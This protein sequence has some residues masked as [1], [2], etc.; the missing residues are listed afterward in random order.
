MQ[1]FVT[2]ILISTLGEPCAENNESSEKCCSKD[3]FVWQMIDCYNTNASRMQ[4]GFR[5]T[6]EFRLYCAYIRMV[7]GRLAY[8]TFKAN[9]THSVPSRCSVDRFIRQVQS[10][11]VEGVLRTEE[12]SKYLD[13]L[14]LPRI[15]ALSEDATKIVDRIQYD[16]STN[17]LLGFVLPLQETNGMPLIGGNKATSASAIERCFFDFETGEERKKSTYINVVMAQP[18]VRGIP[19]ICILIF[20]SDTHYSSKDIQKRWNFIENELRKKNIEVLSFASDSDPKFNSVMRKQLNLGC[21]SNDLDARA[22]YPAY[23]N[24]DFVANMSQYVPI[25][26]M[27]H[28]GTKMRNGMIRKK[29]IFG[30]NVISIEH[31]MNLTREFDKAQHK[32]CPSTVIPSDKMNVESVLR[33]C[34]EKVIS[35]LSQVEDKESCK[36]TILY[37]EIMSKILRSFLDMRLKHLERIRY[38]WFSNF[39]LRIWRESVIAH[40]DYT[41][42]HNFIS[43]NCYSCVEINC[44]SLVILM[45]YMK[46]RNLDNLFHLELLGS[47]SCESIFRQIRSLSSTYSTVTNANLF[48]IIHKMSK[49][50]LQNEIAYIKLRNFDFP[51]IGKMRSSYYPTIDRNGENQYFNSEPLPSLDEIFN[52]IELAKMEAIECA[53]SLGV[54]LKNFDYVCKIGLTKPKKVVKKRNIS[55][56]RQNNDFDADVLQL[57]PNI[58]LRQYS[59]KIK[60]NDI[61]EKSIYVKVKSIDGNL[62]CVKKNTLCWLL[63]KTTTKLSSDRLV[64]FMQT[65]AK[66]AKVKTKKT[67]KVVSKKT[68]KRRIT[69]RKNTSKQVTS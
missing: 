59:D 22:E 34:D 5:Y 66:P 4:S 29:F 56:S 36:G 69:T 20:G 2:Q 38:L 52:E 43:N 60:A 14:N 13:D 27:E 16:K 24:A 21:A 32:L 62:Y 23:F 28:I 12:L 64:K 67:I 44:H 31:V 3:T 65:T 11:A 41:L 6:E 7:G 49:I 55:V 33:I 68:T 40:Q 53:E 26:D 9:A 37:L 42:K 47:Q 25:Q 10:N 1:Y 8:E 58:N 48:E 39:I 35:L 45:C 18:L 51:R 15:V 57:F 50:E 61:D 17:Q 46:Q 19:P 30:E 54:S 63:D